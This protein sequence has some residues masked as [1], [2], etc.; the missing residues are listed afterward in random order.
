MSVQSQ[1]PSRP[2]LG[3][4]LVSV[5]P[6]GLLALFGAPRAQENDAERA[7]VAGL[8]L[9]Q[10]LATVNGTRPAGVPALQLQVGVASGQVVGLIDELPTCQELIDRIIAD[11]EATLTRLAGPG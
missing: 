6:D 5:L 10:A 1:A 7:V 3:S 4:D 2:D 11:A 8:A 9:H